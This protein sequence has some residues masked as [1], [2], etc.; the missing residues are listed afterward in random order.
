[1]KGTEVCMQHAPFEQKD[2]TSLYGWPLLAPAGTPWLRSHRQFFENRLAVS[3]AVAS[4]VRRRTTPTGSRGVDYI[5][6]R[7]ASTLQTG[8]ALETNPPPV[9]ASE[10]ITNKAVETTDLPMR[11]GASD[12]KTDGEMFSWIAGLSGGVY[13]HY[14]GLGDSYRLATAQSME[15]PMFMQF[16][17]YR[18]RLNAIWRDM[19]RIVLQAQERYNKQKYETYEAHIA[20]DR[21]VEADLE[22]ISTA[23]GT[24][25][26]DVINPQV[27]AGTIPD[28]TVENMT[29]YGLQSVL[30]SIGAED[31]Q[32]MVNV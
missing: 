1:R 7:L 14:L 11:T 6:S 29:V 8:G 12:A 31:V 22:G 17:L 19:V 20:A 26:R 2:E 18:N 23:V 21:L 16:S 5:R 24:T 3:R 30:H 27:L 9:A 4:Y 25:F 15:K 28:E 10:D 32:E 13:P